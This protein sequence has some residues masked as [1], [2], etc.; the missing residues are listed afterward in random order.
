MTSRLLALGVVAL[1]LNGMFPCVSWSQPKPPPPNPNAPNL[2]MPGP[3][4]MQRGT[5]LDLLLTGGNLANPT[6]FWT[7]APAK[8]AIPTTDKNG[9]DAGKLTVRL[10]VP[11]DAPLGLYA[12]RLAN[13]S[14]VSNLRLFCIDDLPTVVEVAPNRNKAT[15]QA[16][17]VP[18][19]VAGTTAAEASN[20][21]KI[22]AKAG[23][24]L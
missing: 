23:Q 4:G 5:A 11:A 10:E 9:T 7:S 13:K 19:V 22:T 18:C 20:W 15:P 21:F 8:V 17:P 3:M 1:L 24:R 6:G 2:N 14:G 16:V 12:C